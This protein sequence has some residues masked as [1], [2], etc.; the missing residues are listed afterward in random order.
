MT[1]ITSAQW[2]KLTKTKREINV[3]LPNWLNLCEVSI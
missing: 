2:K 1:W 3:R